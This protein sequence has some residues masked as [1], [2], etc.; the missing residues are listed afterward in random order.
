MHRKLKKHADGDAHRVKKGER[1]KCQSGIFPARSGALTEPGTR[2]GK[3]ERKP[4]YGPSIYRFPGDWEAKEI[5]NTDQL[6]QKAN[7]LTLTMKERKK[8]AE[9]DA[10]M[11][12]NVL[13]FEEK[14]W[15]RSLCST[16][17]LS[18][19]SCTE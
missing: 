2:G 5:K 4:G 3:Q 12:S 16:L 14:E 7:G 18:T 6:R 15:K 9:K 11:N 13:F 8:K 1:T 19:P 10:P 17:T